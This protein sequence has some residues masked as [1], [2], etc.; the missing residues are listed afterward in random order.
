MRMKKIDGQVQLRPQIENIR[1]S[2]QHADEPPSLISMKASIE[3]G[4]TILDSGFTTKFLEKKRDLPIQTLK[5]KTPNILKASQRI[6]ILN[7]RQGSKESVRKS[8]KMNLIEDFTNQIVTQPMPSIQVD[9]LRCRNSQKYNYLNKSYIM[10][11]RKHF[12]RNS[13]L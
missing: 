1:N 12:Y 7:S 3:S 10:P 4:G 11:P 5:P 13:L 8:S 9:H 2:Y 6:S